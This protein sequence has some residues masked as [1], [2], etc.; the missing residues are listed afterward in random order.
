VGEDSDIFSTVKLDETNHA[1][2]AVLLKGAWYLV[3]T[4]WDAGQVLE[5]KWQ[6]NFV[7][8]W[9]LCEPEAMVWRHLPQNPIWQLKPT[10]TTAEEFARIPLFEEGYFDEFGNAPLELNRVN[11]VGGVVTFTLPAARDAARVSYA[12]WNY[13]MKTGKNRDVPDCIWRERKGSLESITVAFPNPGKYMFSVCLAEKGDE[14][15]VSGSNSG[16]MIARLGFEATDSGLLNFPTLYPSPCEFRLLEPLSSPLLANTKYRFRF[17]LSKTASLEAYTNDYVE[18]HFCTFT[19]VVRGDMYE[20]EVTTPPGGF[21]SVAA[22][23]ADSSVP[24]FLVQFGI[25]TAGPA[26]SRKEVD[27]AAIPLPGSYVVED[28]FECSFTSARKLAIN[29]ELAQTTSSG[30]YLSNSDRMIVAEVGKEQ[31]LSLYFP[32]AGEFD[33]RVTANADG[34]EQ[35]LNYHF[36]SRKGT[37]LNDFFTIAVNRFL[38]TDDADGL[39]RMSRA[40]PYREDLKGKWKGDTWYLWGPIFDSPIREQRNLLQLASVEGKAKIAALCLACEADPNKCDENGL[41]P[42]AM[43]V[44]AGHQ[45]IVR[46][47]LAKGADPNTRD[48]SGKTTLDYAKAGKDATILALIREAVKK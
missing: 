34:Y 4:T 27:V 21:L 24:Q 23:T 37:T 46:L 14:S 42:L 1:W 35:E 19:S 18:H 5:G 38:E 22:K 31:H 40:Q 39:Y 6:R 26:K 12:L 44:Q 7:T 28:H 47:L 48:R 30:V 33:V 36:T 9:F 32:G 20:F 11:R 8:G 17:A 43:G 45:D 2:N 15:G 41:T 10:E 3:D 16:T 25:T 29:C 13:P